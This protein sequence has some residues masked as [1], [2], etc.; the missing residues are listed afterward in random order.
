MCIARPEETPAVPL[1]VREIGGGLWSVTCTVVTGKAVVK[2][3]QLHCS[4]RDP[5]LVFEPLRL[6]KD[7]NFIPGDHDRNIH[8]VPADPNAIE[9]LRAHGDHRLVLIPDPTFFSRP[10]GGWRCYHSGACIP[11]GCLDCHDLE[12]DDLT[13]PEFWRD[14]SSSPGARRWMPNGSFFRSPPFTGNLLTF[15][16]VLTKHELER[17]FA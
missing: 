12:L 6:T 9:A 2:R 11:L 3:G 13:I 4:Q 14:A 7:P 1:S 15:D 10:H 17:V 16:R 8:Q 5:S